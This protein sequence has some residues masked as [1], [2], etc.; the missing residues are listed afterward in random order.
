MNR[1]NIT[2]REYHITLRHYREYLNGVVKDNAESI[3]RVFPISF[4]EYL[5]RFNDIPQEQE[6]AMK[7]AL[8]VQLVLELVADNKDKDTPVGGIMKVWGPEY[9]QRMNTFANFFT[10]QKEETTNDSN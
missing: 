9:I 3:N 5:A 2:D 4:E 10:P 7:A 1:G 8:V 6:D